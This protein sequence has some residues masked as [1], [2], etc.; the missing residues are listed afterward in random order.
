MDKVPIIEHIKNN[1]N[2]LSLPQALMEVIEE[3]GKEDYSAESLSKIILK[4]PSLT[5]KIL[6]MA[7]SPF[8]H[9][10]AEIK[11]VQQAVSILGV[12]TV[13][14]IALSTSLLHPEKIAN[15]AGV[16]PKSFFSYTLSVAAASEQIAKT[17]EYK[18]VDEAFIAG[19]LLDIGILFLVHHYPE[20]YSKVIQENTS[21]QSLLDAE[22]DI[23]QVS[24]AEIGYYLAK[25]WGLPEYVL[26]AIRNHHDLFA[27]DKDEVLSN[28]VKLAV[29]LTTDEFSGFEQPLEHRLEATSKM[30]ELL[31]M[32]KSDVEKISFTLLQHTKET[33]DY[34]G[35]DIG[36]YED[37]LVKANQEIC[38]SYLTIE[39]LFKERQELSQ[40]L[41]REERERG[42]EETKN[43]AMATLSHY[44]NNAVM[45]IYGR[46]QIMRLQHKKGNLQLINEKLPAH[47]DIIDKSVQKIVAVLEEMKKISPLDAKRFNQLSEALNIDEKLEARLKKM[48]ES[49]KLGDVVIYEEI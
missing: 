4:D 16:D 11:T 18:A 15:E 43:V 21:Y 28:I 37:L 17:I 38:K 44:L 5:G 27:S 26:N 32:S 33:A 31:D 10:M 36:S 24:H 22:Q 30:A 41:L 2:L 3:L 47:L 6:K 34:L 42:A 20:E 25:S 12:T 49:G 1:G 9:R 45:A 46:S 48:E 23:F 14:C 13:K 29:L 19:L 7:N 40:K 35:V 39:N 8:Y